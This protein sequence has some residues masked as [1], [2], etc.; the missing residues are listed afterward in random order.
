[1]NFENLTRP[2]PIHSTPKLPSVSDTV[3]LSGND[4]TEICFVNDVGIA[5]TDADVIR[6]AVNTP[7]PST[8]IKNKKNT[9]T[10][11][12]MDLNAIR[13]TSTKKKNKKNTLITSE[14]DLNAIP[15]TI[16]SKTNK[17]VI[18]SE[19]ENNKIKKN[20]VKLVMGLDFDE[21]EL[22]GMLDKIDISDTDT[23]VSLPSSKPKPLKKRKSRKKTIKSSKKLLDRAAKS[24]SNP[25]EDQD[26][27]PPS[28]P[29]PLMKGKSMKKTT[30]S[31]KNLRKL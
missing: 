12:E 30:K 24:F 18:E 8:R 27:L 25:D 28:K 29:K 6:A 5:A 3:L 22:S 2:I 14:I 21:E 10:T 31:S 26:S 16:N 15:A 19:T 7:T 17:E 11:S 4:A 9:L 20:S 1:M 13:T 23:Q